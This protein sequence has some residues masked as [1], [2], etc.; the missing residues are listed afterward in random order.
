MKQVFKYFLVGGMAASFD[1]GFF[2]LFAGLL[3]FHWLPVSIASFILATLINYIISINYVFESGARYQK[4]LEIASIFL[5]SGSALVFNQIVLYTA[6]VVF[7]WSLFYSKITATG[8]VFF[9]NY[10]WRSLWLF[11]TPSKAD[12]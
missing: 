8:L 11:K 3:D 1:I 5:I 4:K 6:I 9:W 12:N 10:L 7:G 2:M